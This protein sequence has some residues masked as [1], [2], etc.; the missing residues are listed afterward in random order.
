VIHAF[1]VSDDTTLSGEQTMTDYV[2]SI[3]A[4]VKAKNPNE[5][6]FHQAVQEVL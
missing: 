6:E 2:S 4:E 3:M 5:P 1:S